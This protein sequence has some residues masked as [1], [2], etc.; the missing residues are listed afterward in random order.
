MRLS[1][2]L[3]NGDVSTGLCLASRMRSTRAFLS[4]LMMLCFFNAVQLS[5]C[6][7]VSGDQALDSEFSN[8]ISLLSFD[9][10]LTEMACA[11][12]MSTP[13]T[14]ITPIG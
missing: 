9:A 12:I 5:S 6:R 2:R 13:R 1:V 10:K 11:G 14:K 3:I 8:L 7:T 4:S